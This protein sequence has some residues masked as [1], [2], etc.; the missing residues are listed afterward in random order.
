[1]GA[2]TV[3]VILTKRELTILAN[4]INEA[5]EAVEAWEFSTRVGADPAEAEE[6]RIKISSLLD[7]MNQ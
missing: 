2:A 6:L 5:R 4:S 1:M 7:S 3:S